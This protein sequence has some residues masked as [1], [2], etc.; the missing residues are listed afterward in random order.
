MGCSGEYYR[1]GELLKL[2][3]Y[4]LNLP[5]NEVV[6][7]STKDFNK[8]QGRYNDWGKGSKILV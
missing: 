5:I 3:Y 6:G 8:G 1:V 4:P 2:N 7:S